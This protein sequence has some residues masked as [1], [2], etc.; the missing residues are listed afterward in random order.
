MWNERYAQPGFAY[1]TAPNDFLVETEPLLPRGARIL[2]LA[3]GEGRNAVWLAERGHH[4]VAVDGSDVGL[5]KATHLARER[6]VTI[7]TVVA[8]LADYDIASET[9][10]AIISIWAHV[11][12]ELRRPLHARCARGLRP[13]G[14]MLLEAYTPSQIRRGTGGPRD[15]AMCMSAQTLREEL[16]GLVFE[17]VDERT[18]SIAEGP[19]HDGPS[20]VVQMVARKPG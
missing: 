4:V 14:V 6:G 5:A 11:P 3:E 9:F 12:P 1:G 16:V 13:G 19:Y 20:D 17:R 8:N 10:D 7:E 18:R 15:P 2:S